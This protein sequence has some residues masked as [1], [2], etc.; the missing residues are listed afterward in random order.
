MPYI[1]RN[2]TMFLK[3]F[4]QN[5]ITRTIANNAKHRL[6]PYHHRRYF[7]AVSSHAQ[8]QTQTQTSFGQNI[9]A[10]LLCS[11]W[12]YVGSNQRRCLDDYSVEDWN[13]LMQ[14]RKIYEQSQKSKQ[15]IDLLLASQNAPTFGYP[16]NNYQHCLQSATKVY[17]DMLQNKK[18]A[19]FAIDEELVVLSLFHD[20]FFVVSNENHAESISVLLRPFICDR[21]AWMLRYHDKFQLIHAKNL[22]HISEKQKKIAYE[23]WGKS[24]SKHPYFEFTAEWV[25]KYDQDAMD[26]NFKS[27]PIETFV[28]MVNRFF[29]K[30]VYE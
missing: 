20:I 15:A 3:K 27:E 9:S 25:A 14:Q 16:V 26:P 6:R 10:P 2:C 29:T 22:L 18:I 21:N 12:K 24:K 7:C 8:I 30:N 28:P 11:E 17:Y 4:I 5:N 23:T 1:Y 13:I 19:G